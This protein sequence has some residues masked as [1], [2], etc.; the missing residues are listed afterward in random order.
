MFE[1]LTD[2]DEFT[3]ICDVTDTD[4]LMVQLIASVYIPPSSLNVHT[5]KWI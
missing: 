1:N 5:Y 3:A 4:C 2:M